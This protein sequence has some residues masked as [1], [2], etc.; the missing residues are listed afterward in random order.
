[1]HYDLRFYPRGALRSKHSVR[2]ACNSDEAQAAKD[3]A[4]VGDLSVTPAAAIPA[5][6]SRSP[7]GVP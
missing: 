7:A 5:T 6:Q 1:M 2:S 4:S 3:A